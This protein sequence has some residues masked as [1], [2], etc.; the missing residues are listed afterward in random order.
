MSYIPEPP[1][2]PRPIVILGAGGIVRDA[3]LP[4]YRKAGFTVTGIYNR[5]RSR[6]QQLADEYSIPVVCDNIEEAIG[7]APSNAVFDLALMPPQ[8]EKVLSRLPKGSPVLIQKPMGDNLQQA[9]RIR[10]ICEERQLAAAVNCQLR[11]APYVMAA[12]SLLNSGDLGTLYDLEIK[13]IG[14]AHV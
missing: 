2:A 11:Y 7:A 1:K 12:R 14:R 5:T 10:R 6:A 8:F 4:A 13:E 9:K 3:H